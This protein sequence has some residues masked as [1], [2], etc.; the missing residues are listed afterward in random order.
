MIFKHIV[1]NILNVSQLIF[2]HPV[3]VYTNYLLHNIF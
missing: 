3:K 1:E 2:V